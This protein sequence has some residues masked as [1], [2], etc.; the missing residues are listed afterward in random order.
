MPPARQPDQSAPAHR[1]PDRRRLRRPEGRPGPPRPGRRPADHAQRGP[2]PRQRPLAQGGAARA[3]PPRGLPPAREDHALRPRADPRA[4][5]ARPRCRRARR[6]HRQRHGGEGHPGRRPGREG[7]AD[8]GLRPL[9]HRPRLPRLGRHGAR[10]PR[11]RDEV[12]HEGRHLGPGRQQH[13]G[14]LHPGRDQVPRHHPRRQAAP[15]P[16]DPAGAVGARHLLGLRHAP[17]RGHAPHDLEHERPGHPAQLPDDG[18]LRRPHLPAGRTP[19]RK[20]VPGQVP[21]EAAAGRALPDLGG[22]ADRRRVRP[23]LP[24]PR[25]LRRHRGRRLPRVGPRHPGLPRHPGRDLRGHRP[26]RP[27]QDRARG[28]GPGAARSARWCSTAT[29]RTSSP[30]PSRSPSTPAT[31]CR[32]SRAPTTR[33]CRAATSPTSTPSSPGSAGRTSPRSR[34]TGRTRRST[35]TPAT[36]STSRRVHDGPAPYTPNSVDDGVP[37]PSDWAEGGYVNVPRRVEGEVVRGGA[38]VLRRPLLPA[39]DVLREPDRRSSS[40]TWPTRTPSSS[41]SATSRRSR[42]GR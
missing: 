38:G 42:S 9:L 2:D 22:G 20:T 37:F 16:G 6:V 29:R 1:Q 18:G 32:A 31:W 10:H 21:L 41:A 8:A 19:T 25:P 34:S 12:L 7:P 26:A 14:L 23:R 33:C 17:H 40:S 39:G 28:A 30:R 36:A 4:R 5:G 27:D 15:R 3:G 24:P 11:V 35:T 13:A